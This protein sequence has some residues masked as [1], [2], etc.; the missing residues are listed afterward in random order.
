[1]LSLHFHNKLT[2]GA[3]YASMLALKNE[4]SRLLVYEIVIIVL[5]YI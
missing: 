5:K 3:S 1:M 4:V 2:I